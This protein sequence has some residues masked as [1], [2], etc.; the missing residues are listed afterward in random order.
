MSLWELITHRCG[1]GQF[2][3]QGYADYI[4]NIKAICYMVSEDFFP[5]HL[6]DPQGTTKLVHKGAVG[7]IYAG[8]HKALLYTM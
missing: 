8:D 5:N 3:R 7:T 6:T 4:L 1:G 2:E